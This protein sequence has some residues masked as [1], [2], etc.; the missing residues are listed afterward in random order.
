MTER[1]NHVFLKFMLMTASTPTTQISITIS[2]KEKKYQENSLLLLYTSKNIL[3]KKNQRV[4]FFSS[5]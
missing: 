1:Q 3:K 5:I 4:A 2:E